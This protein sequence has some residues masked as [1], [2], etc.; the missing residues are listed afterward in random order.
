MKNKTTK[1]L[2]TIDFVERAK[3]IHNDKY[4]YSLSTYV[5]THIKVKII[6]P[7]H[8]VFEQSPHNHLAGFNCKQCSSENTGIERRVKLIDFISQANLMHNNY[9]DYSLV[10]Y[11]SAIEKVDIVCPIHGVFKQKPNAHIGQKQGCPS[12]YHQKMKDNGG[13]WSAIA[14]HN[15]G[16]K[17]KN[18]DG[19]KLYVI[20]CFNENEEFIKIGKT[21]NKLKK[22]FSQIPYKYE[23]IKTITSENGEYIHELEKR[24]KRKYNKHTYLPKT[25]FGGMYECFKV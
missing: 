5:T 10:E 25:K 22:R 15:T 12:C 18:F 3:I 8:G 7:I 23:I 13:T 16:I 14:W 11:V 17:S 21:F 19:F 24:V 6:C 4:D 9:Y 20:R 2:T 1:K